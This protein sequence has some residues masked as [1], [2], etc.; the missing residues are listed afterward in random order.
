MELTKSLGFRTSVSPSGG[1]EGPCTHSLLPSKAREQP[2][3]QAATCL[4]DTPLLLFEGT[5]K[6][7]LRLSLWHSLPAPSPCTTHPCF[8]GFLTQPATGPRVP[9]SLPPWGLAALALGLAC[10]PPL[11]PLALHFEPGLQPSSGFQ[12][13]HARGSCGRGRADPFRGSQ[14]DL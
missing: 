8:S 9:G 2:W 11:L 10:F 3:S 1:A 5:R 12:A 4:S 7:C 6:S 13:W 14:L